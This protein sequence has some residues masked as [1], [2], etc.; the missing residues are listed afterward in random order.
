MWH[1]FERCIKAVAGL[2]GPAV[3]LSRGGVLGV[4]GESAEHRCAH[5]LEAILLCCRSVGQV[6]S[7]RFSE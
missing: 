6:S 5:G 2:G 7:I 3:D 1:E 4:K